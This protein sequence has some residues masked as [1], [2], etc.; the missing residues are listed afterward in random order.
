MQKASVLLQTLSSEQYNQNWQNS[1]I[2]IFQT[3]KPIQSGKCLSYTVD[4]VHFY[5]VKLAQT[6]LIILIDIINVVLFIL[7]QLK[8]WFILLVI[9]I[10]DLPQTKQNFFSSMDLIISTIVFMTT[11]SLTRFLNMRNSIQAKQLFYICMDILNH[12]KATACA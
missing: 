11:T 1:F 12:P 2:F 7:F 9:V 10:R 8:L 6:N 5:W 3:S 4:C